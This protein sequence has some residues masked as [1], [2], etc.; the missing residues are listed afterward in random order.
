MTL[1]SAARTPAGGWSPAGGIALR[2]P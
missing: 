2:L 1:A